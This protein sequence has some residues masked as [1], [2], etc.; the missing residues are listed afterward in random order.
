MVVVVVGGGTVVVVVVVVGGVVVVV[1]SSP[2]T[3]KRAEAESPSAWAATVWAPLLVRTG[4]ETLTLNEPESSAVV[5]LKGTTPSHRIV[6]NAP[7]SNP[8]PDTTKPLPRVPLSG[9][10][11]IEAAKATAGKSAANRTAIANTDSKR[12]RR[13][14][15]PDAFSTTSPPTIRVLAA[16]RALLPDSTRAKLPM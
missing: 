5:R 10:S 1:V 14:G 11:D 4:T 13:P 12:R 16:S 7:E 9:A 8:E 3:T 15:R 6:T 2:W